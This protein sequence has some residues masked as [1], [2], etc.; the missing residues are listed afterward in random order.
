M[1]A[2]RYCHNK[3]IAHRDVKLEN[4]LLQKFSSQEQ[5]HH[6]KLIDFGF[7]NQLPKGEKTRTFCGTPSYMSPEIV[8]RKEHAGPPVDIWATGILLYAL[9]CGYFPFRATNDNELYKKIGIG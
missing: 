2:L 3:N 8:T 1:D 6:V 9:I 5:T 7:A 4:V